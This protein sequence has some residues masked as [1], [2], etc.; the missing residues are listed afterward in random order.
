MRLHEASRRSVL[1]LFTLSLRA[2]DAE[3]SDD[4]IYDQ[5]NRQLVTDRD[6]GAHPLTIQVKQGVVTVDGFVESEKARKKIDKLVRKI[7]G[8]KDVVNRTQVRADL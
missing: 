1:A 6:L 2:Q 4:T 5:V 8:V 3:V 7:K